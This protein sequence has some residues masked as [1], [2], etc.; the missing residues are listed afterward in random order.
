[1]NQKAIEQL[2]QCPCCER[3]YSSEW[4]EESKEEFCQQCLFEEEFN[5]DSKVDEALLVTGGQGL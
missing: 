5:I 2:E 1:M 3:F 4:F